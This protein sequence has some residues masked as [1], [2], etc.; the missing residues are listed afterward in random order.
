MGYFFFT[1]LHFKFIYLYHY[2][3]IDAMLV[4]ST[5]LRKQVCYGFPEVHK[6]EE[7]M[8]FISSLFPQ[9]DAFLDCSKWLFLSL[10]ICA[11]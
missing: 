9:M 11:L 1:A 5:V 4:M 7:V 8:N 2:Y 10:K 6:T 3:S